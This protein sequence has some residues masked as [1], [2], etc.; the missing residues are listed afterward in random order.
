MQVRRF[1]KTFAQLRKA[2]PDVFSVGQK[3]LLDKRQRYIV[4]TAL[5]E[6]VVSLDRNF[7]LNCSNLNLC[8]YCINCYSCEF[9]SECEDCRSSVCLERC[10]GARRCWYDKNRQFPVTKPGIYRVIGTETTI[11]PYEHCSIS[12][13]QVRKYLGISI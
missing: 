7:N 1:Y 5:K 11:S 2:H 12:G 8:W 9:C 13:S 6:G 4:D 10:I 3:R